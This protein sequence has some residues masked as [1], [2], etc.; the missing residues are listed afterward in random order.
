MKLIN[1]IWEKRNTGLKTCEI[2]FEKGD[3]IQTY[4]DAN[5]ETN[6]KLSVVKIPIGNLKL[7]HQLEDTEYRYLENQL[8]LTFEV[9]QL[10]EI[11]PIWT[12]LLEGFS[13]KLLTTK[14]EL[15][16]VLNEVSNKMFETDRFSLDPFWQKDLSSKRYQ[17]W[18][19]ELFESGIAQFYVIVKNGKEIGFFSI[20]E[21]S[22]SVNNCPIAGIYNKYKSVGYI[23]VLTWFWL[24]KNKEIGKKKLTTSI[25]SNNRMILSSLSGIFSFRI[26]GIFV[27][28]RKLIY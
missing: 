13:C 16:S 12:R 25:S 28:L 10:K 1:A 18:I 5:V 26:S 2:I 4:L 3:T 19:T 15:D 20:K 9:N 17:N 27:V 23:F 8:V 22:K 21:E 7:I 11:N 24:V 14:G 6:F